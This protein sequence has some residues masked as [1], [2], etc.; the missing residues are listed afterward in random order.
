ML[1]TKYSNIEHPNFTNYNAN[2]LFIYYNL[3]YFICLIKL[4]H[5]V[6][7]IKVPDS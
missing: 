3:F 4:K 2:I 7:K 6:H 5:E 1:V